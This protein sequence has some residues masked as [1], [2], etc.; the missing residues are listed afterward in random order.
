MRAPADG[1]F[2]PCSQLRT[3]VKVDLLDICRGSAEESAIC[4]SCNTLKRVYSRVPAVGNRPDVNLITVLT[5]GQ[6]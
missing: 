1:R 2:E 4:L 6:L 5:I 3:D